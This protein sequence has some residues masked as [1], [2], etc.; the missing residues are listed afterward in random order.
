MHRECERA[1]DLP[2]TVREAFLQEEALK[3]SP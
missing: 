2:D 1:P 3:L